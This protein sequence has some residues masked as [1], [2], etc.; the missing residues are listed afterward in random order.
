MSSDNLPTIRQDQTVVE[1]EEADYEIIDSRNT[2][3][4]RSSL[5]SLAGQVVKTAVSAALDWLKERSAS[6][7]S[8]INRGDEAS[9]TMRNDT[10]QSLAGSSGETGNRVSVMR[11][12]NR[13][14]RGK[15]KSQCRRSDGQ[16]I[17]QRKRRWS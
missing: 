13:F 2:N 15:F 11:G 3:L 12:S 6:N 16:R 1:S 5:S 9:L 14:N 17:R 4:V 8:I 7:R 10:R